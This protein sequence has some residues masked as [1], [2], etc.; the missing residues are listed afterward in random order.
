[1]EALPFSTDILQFIEWLKNPGAATLIFGVLAALLLER[2]PQ[3]KEW[4]SPIKSA[5]VFIAFIAFPFLVKLAAWAVIQVPPDIVARVQEY[6]NLAMLGVAAWA[7][8]QGAHSVDP[9]KNE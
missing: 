5:V 9:K 8:S 6:L 3:F 7:S 1:M 4:R 2:V